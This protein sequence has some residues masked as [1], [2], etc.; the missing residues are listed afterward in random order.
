MILIN[1]HLE[2]IKKAVQKSRYMHFKTERETL[3]LNFEMYVTA[4]VR[5]SPP[6]IE[7]SSIQLWRPKDGLSS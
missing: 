3:S 5:I 6:T 1:Y 4:L 2:L 7:E